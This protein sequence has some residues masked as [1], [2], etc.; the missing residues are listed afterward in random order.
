MTTHLLKIFV[1]YILSMYSDSVYLIFI[2]QI[3]QI[4]RL[5][6]WH[7]SCYIDFLQGAIPSYY[8]EFLSLGVPI[9]ASYLPKNSRHLCFLPT[10]LYIQGLH[11]TLPY[12]ES[13]NYQQGPS[14]V[15]KMGY[16]YVQYTRSENLS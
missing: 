5:S 9:F 13:L 12:F 16:V 10:L 2:G 1:E 7:K 8:Q 6:N 15:L 14:F 11:S 4:W 3:K